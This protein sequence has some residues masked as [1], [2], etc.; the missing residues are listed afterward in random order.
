MPRTMLL[1]LCCLAG[2]LPV[3]AADY[4]ELRHGLTNSRLVFEQTQKGRVAFLGGSITTMAGWKELVSHNLQRR[5]PKTQ[6][7]FINA[8]MPS[9]GSTPGAFRLVR[10]V[11]KNG[12]VDLL[13]EEAAVN[14]LY[15]GRSDDEQIRAMEG[16]VRHAR[17]L[18]P[19]I[20]IVIMH[21]VDPPKMADYN[22]GAIPAVIKNHERV[23][24]HYHL[25]SINLA[26]EVTERIKRG[27]FTW[28][29]D[30]KDLHPSPFGHKIYSSTIGR[31]F[32]AAWSKRT[33]TVKTTTY[34]L[35]EKLDE[36]C[37]D[38][39][40]LLMPQRAK[41]LKGFKRV[42]KW[43]NTVGGGTRPGFVDVQMLVG[44]QPGDSFALDFKGTAV[45]L[46]VAA[47]PDAGIIEF[48]IDGGFWIEQDLYTKWSAGLHIPWLYV[49]SSQLNPEEPH[50]LNVRISSKKN[51]K[52]KGHACR[53]VYLAINGN[54]N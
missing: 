13:F 49:F 24:E 1:V 45:G 30:F 10:D 28:E 20:D 15:N 17:T 31:C 4:F 29:D 25:P 6:F 43:T 35:P 3:S 19:N 16:I 7:E 26:L 42:E 50:E 47:G 9:T 37:Y 18:N 5:F 32:N 8:G 33:K 52:S 27:E 39:G 46:F 53:V 2:H 22:R 54:E 38:L 21:F 40:R 23:A 11:F 44:Q 14:D 12:Q 34:P 36:T 48:R 41:A 51:E